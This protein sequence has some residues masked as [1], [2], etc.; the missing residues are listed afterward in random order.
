MVEETSHNKKNEIFFVVRNLRLNC[1]R[2]GHLI[3]CLSQNE[4]KF[5]KVSKYLVHM[6]SLH[7]VIWEQAC[8]YSARPENLEQ[9]VVEKCALNGP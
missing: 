5:N 2:A 9:R 3:C 1:Q 6:F 4:V 7:G 8:V